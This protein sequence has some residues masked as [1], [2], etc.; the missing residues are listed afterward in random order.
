MIGQ[1]DRLPHTLVPLALA[2]TLVQSRFSASTLPVSTEP[3]AIATFIASTVPIWEYSDDARHVPK[4]LPNPIRA[5]VFRDGGRELIF[6]DGRPSKFRLAVQV[7]DVDCVVEM[8]KHPERAL[9]IRN[10]V[11]RDLARTLI[12][13]ARSLRTASAK[14]VN[15][16]EALRGARRGGD[17]TREACVRRAGYCGVPSSP[18]RRDVYF[19]ATSELR[20]ASER[21]S[22]RIKST[23]RGIPRSA[24]AIRR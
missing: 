9:R 16:A 19:A 14:I 11:I 8:L 4:P 3:N 13:K 2:V 5:G 7:N 15:D 24:L 12:Q 23:R 22:S 6:L 17:L 10:R 21:C 20:L 18:V 1:D